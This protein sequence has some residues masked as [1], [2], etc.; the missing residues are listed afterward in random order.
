[1][2]VVQINK[3]YQCPIYCDVGHNHFVYYTDKVDNK[4]VMSIDEPEYKKLK[5]VYVLKK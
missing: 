3:K 4:R 1:M 5:K 2:N